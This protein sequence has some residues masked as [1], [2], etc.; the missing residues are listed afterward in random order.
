MKILIFLSALSIFIF[1]CHGKKKLTDDQNQKFK[2]WC[3]TTKIESMDSLTASTEC[4]CFVAN[5]NKYYPDGGK[6]S[7]REKLMLQGCNNIGTVIPTA[8]DSAK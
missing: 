7:E 1:S 3:M 8:T 5:L 2:S 6:H 4:D